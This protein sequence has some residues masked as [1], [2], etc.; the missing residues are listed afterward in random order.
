MRIVIHS[1][2]VIDPAN[3]LEKV[4]NVVINDDKIE[5]VGNTNGLS[6]DKEI[7]ASGLVV[8]PG[9]VDLHTHLRDP[10]FT[11][12]ETIQTGAAAAVAGGFT[13]ICCMP[14]TNPLIDNELTV[15]Y[16]TNKASSLN[17]CDIR[18]IGAITKN[19][20]GKQLCDYLSLKSAGCIAFSDDGKPVSDANLLY[21]ALIYTKNNGD[22]IFA[23]HEED[24]SLSKGGIINEGKTAFGLGLKGIPS[25]AESSMIARDIEILR[26]V[27]DARLHICHV[28]AKESIALLKNAKKEGLNI[29]F[30]VTPHHLALTEEEAYNYNT[31]AK[32]NPPLKSKEDLES[33]IEAFKQDLVDAIAT[34]H[35]P[36]ELD[37]KN[38][39]IQ[40]ASFGISGLET[41]FG[42]VNTYLVKKNLISLFKA[43]ELLSTKPA[44][45]F[46]L[47]A[48]KLTEGSLANIVLLD[49]NK[50]W[51]V[52]SNN[53]KSKGKNTPFNLKTLSGNI[54]QTIYKGKT[55][56][57]R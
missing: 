31:Y 45:A 23:L 26:A 18:P 37:S 6:I 13:S 57:R 17:I 5:L 48:G 22:F 51:V 38:V 42:V 39:L 54:E 50:E 36:H 16:I 1:G 41:A 52:D 25:L 44:K 14:N 4:T 20:E 12:K 27:K 11:K 8:C 24:Y 15:S 28:S 47:D 55:V 32:V 34:D 21:T 53:F 9:F 40:D 46:K 33:I 19:Q 29:T 10:G 49:P 2:L 30:E 56:Y 35:A 3:N 43:I 7:D